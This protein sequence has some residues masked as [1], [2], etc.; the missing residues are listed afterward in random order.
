MANSKRVMVQPPVALASVQNE[1]LTPLC[2]N[3]KMDLRKLK[4]NKSQNVIN[5]RTSDNSKLNFDSD[6]SI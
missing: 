3:K 4:V 5:K 2:V 6:M 1:S